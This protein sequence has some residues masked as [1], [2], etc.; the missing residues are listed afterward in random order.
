MPIVT[1]GEYDG[2]YS[3]DILEAQGGRWRKVGKLTRGRY[4]QEISVVNFKDFA[5][6]CNN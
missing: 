1:G 5:K 4:E 6:Y 2:G 3:D